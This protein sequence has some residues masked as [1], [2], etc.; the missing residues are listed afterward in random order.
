MLVKVFFSHTSQDYKIGFPNKQE[1][2]ILEQIYLELRYS[3]MIS[4]RTHFDYYFYKDRDHVENSKDVY[5]NAAI[6]SNA[7]ILCSSQDWFTIGEDELL[8]CEEEYE[9]FMREFDIK[10]K[11]KKLYVLS[12]DK[13]AEQYYLES[14]H[15]TSNK[16]CYQINFFNPKTNVANDPDLTR[17][18]YLEKMNLFSKV[19]IMHLEK[20]RDV[21]K[22]SI[23]IT[24]LAPARD[25]EDRYNL[26]IEELKTILN[27]RNLFFSSKFLNEEKLMNKDGERPTKEWSN[28]ET[29]CLRSAKRIIV[30]ISQGKEKYYTKILRKYNSN[31]L[32]AI[33]AETAKVKSNFQR[34]RT[35][36]K[37]FTFNK[38]KPKY[39]VN[40]IKKFLND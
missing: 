40:K 38:E 9:C 4:V 24:G 35:N 30:F 25:D 15:H 21:I 13:D 14:E 3:R 34:I 20:I 29:E 28:N 23:L 18:L 17:N 1:L 27:P 19:L 26:I 33:V 10:S 12:L 22:D 2:S 39:T 16:K 5:T 37:V 8:P 6:R 36:W 32:V 31:N 7:F 11:N